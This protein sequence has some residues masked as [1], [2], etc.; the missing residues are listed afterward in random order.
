MRPRRRS[1]PG[2]LSFKILDLRLGTPP[3]KSGMKLIP[4]PP[5]RPS[6]LVVRALE[7]RR[8]SHTSAATAYS[9]DSSAGG[10]VGP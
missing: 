4:G 2:S 5:P 7:H 9:Y 3:C 6:C 10:V 1:E 8:S